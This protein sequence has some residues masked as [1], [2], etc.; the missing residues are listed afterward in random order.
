MTWHTDVKIRGLSGWTTR[1]R[2]EAVNEDG[3]RCLSDAG[4]AEHSF[5]EKV[6]TTPADRLAL[7][8]KAAAEGKLKLAVEMEGE[9][10]GFTVQWQSSKGFG[11][12]TVVM[13]DD[14]SIVIDNEG[15]SRKALAELLVALLEQ[16]RLVDER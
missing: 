5:P 4:H 2:C 6:T 13:K 1:P 15:D 8:Q 3:E 10:G 9:R 7:M 16:G 11:E 12:L 14:G